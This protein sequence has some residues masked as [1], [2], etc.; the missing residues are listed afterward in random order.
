[1]S[2]KMTAYLGETKI[3]HGSDGLSGCTQ[4]LIGHI[5]AKIR[6]IREFRVLFFVCPD[7][8]GILFVLLQLSAKVRV[9]KYGEVDLFIRR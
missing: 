6:P 9:S 1:M 5:R 8:S 2:E 3:V 4:I 7:L